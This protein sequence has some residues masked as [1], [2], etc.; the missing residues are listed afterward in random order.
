MLFNE[1]IKQFS[2]V[3]IKQNSIE[4]A[5]ILLIKFLV[6]QW[7]SC[8]LQGICVVYIFVY[9]TKSVRVLSNIVLINH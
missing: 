2:K 5:L 8:Q 3:E 4:S 9:I 6:Y 1:P 7:D